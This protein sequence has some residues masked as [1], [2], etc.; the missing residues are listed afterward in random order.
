MIDGLSAGTH[1]ESAIKQP[2]RLQDP[3]VPVFA[4]C[5]LST[6]GASRIRLPLLDWDTPPRLVAAVEYLDVAQ[7]QNTPRDPA[8]CGIIDE[9]GASESPAG[10]IQKLFFDLP[11]RGAFRPPSFPLTLL[12]SHLSYSPSMR[13]T[14]HLCSLSLLAIAA[15]CRLSFNPDPPLNSLPAR[16]PVHSTVR[17]VASPILNNAERLKQGM[18]PLRPKLLYRT[19]TRMRLCVH[20]RD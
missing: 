10:H 15:M 9:E 3:Y 20:P 14:S 5:A 12:C 7:E 17:R 8:V 4:E 18:T 16:A 11:S 13:L 2:K 6:N 19:C 1:A